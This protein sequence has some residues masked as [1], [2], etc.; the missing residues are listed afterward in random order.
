MSAL[1]PKHREAL[2]DGVW[3]PLVSANETE[4]LLGESADPERITRRVPWP[5][6][7][8]ARSTSTFAR[9]HGAEVCITRVEGDRVG[10]V[11][12]DSSIAGLPGVDGD[13][14]S[15]WGAWVSASELTDVRE[16]VNY[17]WPRDDAGDQTGSRSGWRKW[18]G[19]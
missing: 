6:V 15:G 13:Q 14:H 12:S 9:W 16:D 18:V 1:R 5:Q 11:T 19:R 2:V 3:V 8:K 4:A 10:F 17:F 7:E